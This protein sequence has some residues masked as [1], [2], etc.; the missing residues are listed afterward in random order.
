MNVLDYSI[1][2]G[3]LFRKT[4]E[5]R[6]LLEA[7]N[8]IDEKYKIDNTCFSEYLQY[9]RGKETQFYFFA[10]QVAYDAFISVIDD[11]EFEYRQLFLKTA[12]L[13]KDDNDVKVLIDI[14][15]KVG[16]V[17]DNLSS[18][19]LTGGDVEKN[20]SKE[21]KFKM[22]NAISDVQLAVQRT[23]LASTIASYYG[24]NM[25][26]LNNEITKK[27]LD[28]REARQFLPFSREA[29]SCA[30]KYGEL[31]EEEKTL[32]EKMFLVREAINKGFFYGFWENVN[33]LTADDIIDGNEFNQGVLREIVF[34]HENNTSSFSHSWLYKIWN[35]EGYFYLMAHK[36]EVK[37]IPQEGGK[38]TVTGIIYPTDDRRLFVEEPS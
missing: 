12:E 13:L 24:E 4:E 5:G 9:V 16:K 21:W 28:E 33:E 22:K 20:V 8:S 3:K 30:S 32:Y 1:R 25:N 17:F 37:I 26:L 27:Y 23:L 7:K 15:N 14:A 35:K 38:S 19:C 18:L 34:S 36:K 2:A 11:K 6:A 10:W 29:L 31:S